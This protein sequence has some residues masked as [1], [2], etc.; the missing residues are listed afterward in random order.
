[1]QILHEASCDLL[2]IGQYLQ[3]SPNHLP[4]VKFLTPEEF[5]KLAEKGKAIGFKAVAAAPLVRSSFKA[6][7]IYRRALANAG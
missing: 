1:M 5:D 3:P 6:A 4:I 2:T 7:Q